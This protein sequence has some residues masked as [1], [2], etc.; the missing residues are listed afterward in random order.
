MICMNICY[1][2]YAAAC[3]SKM[4]EHFAVSA[5]YC[6]HK[7]CIFYVKKIEIASF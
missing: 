7:S 6:A 3:L 2:R 5:R 1:E 4:H